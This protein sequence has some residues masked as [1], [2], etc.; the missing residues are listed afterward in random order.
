MDTIS[1]IVEWLLR[2]ITAIRYARERSNKVF[3]PMVEIKKVNLASGEASVGQE[4]APEDLG[5]DFSST[6]LISVQR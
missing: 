5:V 4:I 2:K 3:D 1:I 6:A